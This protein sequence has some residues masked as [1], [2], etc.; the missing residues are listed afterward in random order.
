MAQINERACDRS[1]GSPTVSVAS[2]VRA[3]RTL[4]KACG[5]RNFGD[6]DID[7]YD[8]EIAATDAFAGSVID[9]IRELKKDPAI[10]VTADHGEEFGDHGGRYHGTTVY[11]E[12]VR[13]PLLVHG[14]GVP[15][16][17]VKVPVQTIDLL[18]TVLGALGV[19]VPP[20]LRGR[21][22]GSLLAGQGREAGDRAGFAFA[23]AEHY[24]MVAEGPNR[25]VCERQIGACTLY[26]V[27]KDPRETQRAGDPNDPRTAQTIDTLKALQVKTERAH[28]LFEG[29]RGARMP[30]ALRRAL[31]GD[32]EAAVD[33]AALLDD[34]RPD[35]RLAAADVLFHL[36]APAA[37]SYL[38]RARKTEDKSENLHAI[39]LA[40]ARTKEATLP[41]IGP[42]LAS[43]NELHRQRAGW[44][45]AELEDARGEEMA[46]AL[47]KNRRT[48]DLEEQRELVGA[49]ARI[50]SQR[51]VPVLIEAL[52]DVRLRPYVA[53]A[54]GAMGDARA[55]APL[56]ELFAKE[57]YVGTRLF[58]A[59]A[60]EK[61]GATKELEPGLLHWL[62][63]HEL[64]PG[65]GRF[66]VS[67]RLHGGPLDGILARPR[68]ESLRAEG[69]L[70]V[71]LVVAVDR[72][73][74]KSDTEEPSVRLSG[75]EGLAPQP[76][77]ML[78]T[79]QEDLD[80][81][82]FASETREERGK[83][84]ARRGADGGAP[85][86]SPVR[87]WYFDVLAFPAAVRGKR[88]EVAVLPASAGKVVGL[89]VV[90]LQVR[91]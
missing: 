4:R 32:R 49:L 58:E 48:L 90:P 15:V 86:G 16:G 46:L 27:A 52:G 24:T 57:P 44:L 30:E 76:I 3:P 63:D 37:I 19:P 81:A 14:A 54:L 12:Q 82:E 9:R 38:E 79:N 35:I 23:E 85:E 43:A 72:A 53:V 69:P 68:G 45:L 18:P 70:P 7:R 51:A 75:F 47:F 65:I 5:L 50:K 29:D 34:A 21:N 41:E 78:A 33:V 89:R 67:G 6:S 59:A 10:I 20:R 36:R 91:P 42:I 83:R 62:G 1:Q 71:R 73:E 8:S 84:L 22:L 60:L 74:G 11:E 88:F 55:K 17:E 13:V 87:L 56:L 61:L 66:V 80:R 2:S 26:D 77:P 25:L 64:F 40:L 39:T 31:A 28:G